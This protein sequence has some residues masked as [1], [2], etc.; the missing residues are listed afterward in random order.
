MKKWADDPG[1]AAWSS[2][3]WSWT[4]EGIT[5]A[6]GGAECSLDKGAAKV[7]EALPASSC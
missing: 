3:A 2:V 4:T 7:I 1:E 5:G 6:V